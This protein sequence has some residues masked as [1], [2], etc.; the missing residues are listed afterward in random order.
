MERLFLYNPENDIALGYPGNVR[1]TPPRQA[2]LLAGYGTPLMWWMGGD[3][4]GV[5]KRVH[6][7]KDYDIA[8][9]RWLESVEALFGR[10]PR[11]VEPGDGIV[12][13]RLAPWGWSRHACQVYEEAGVASCLSEMTPECM[14]RIRL[15]S[16]RRSS[17]TVNRRLGELLSEKWGEALLAVPGEE[18]FSEGEVIDAITG[19]GGEYYLKSPWSSSGR[20]VVSTCDMPLDRIKSR[21]A[22][23]IRKQGSVLVERG[24]D[25][26]V[27]FAMLFEADETGTVGYVGLSRFFNERGASY[28][29]NLVQTDR[30]IASG[31]SAYLPDEL[32][33][34][35]RDALAV[36]LGELTSGVYAGKMGVDMMVART[37]GR[38]YALVPCIELNLRMTMG[39][40]A[41]SLRERIGEDGIMRVIPGNAQAATRGALPLVPRN[42]YFNIAFVPDRA[43]LFRHFD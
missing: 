2:V 22:S 13:S 42:G 14:D 4:D 10:G 24:H 26:V 31:L 27:D 25:K 34:D 39:F 18:F 1:F 7:D 5:L 36:V 38:G 9:A 37:P 3:R 33:Q 11:F 20:G 29:G 21:C 8:S 35:V 43:G 17:I 28:T 40:V 23:V 19:G 15:L 30:G 16:H 12:C 32:L 6:S 41:H